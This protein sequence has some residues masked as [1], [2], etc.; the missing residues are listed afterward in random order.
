MSGDDDAVAPKRKRK[1]RLKRPRVWEDLVSADLR[2]RENG[3]GC[4]IGPDGEYIAWGSVEITNRVLGKFRDVQRALRLRH[5]DSGLF[6]ETKFSEF[7]ENGKPHFI[8]II[9]A[10]LADMGFYGKSWQWRPVYS[11]IA[12]EIWRR[13]KAK[14]ERV[15]C[16]RLQ[17]AAEAERAHQLPFD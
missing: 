2:S 14:A 13:R 10:A 4:P 5:L 3:R 17:D 9:R 7:T 8:A 12:R 1:K 16:R 6:E 15:R 11:A